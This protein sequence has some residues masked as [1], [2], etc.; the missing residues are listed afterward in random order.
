MVP[1]GSPWLLSVPSGSTWL[2][3]VAPGSPWIV[4][5]LLELVLLGHPNS[6]EKKGRR[7]AEEYS[8]S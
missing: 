5:T 4:L 6:F 3:L 8:R 7:L 1:S 2:L